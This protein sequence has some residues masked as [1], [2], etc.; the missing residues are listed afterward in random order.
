MQREN[1]PSAPNYT[2]AALAMG[3]INLLWIFILL[4]VAFGLPIVLILG[5]L[6]NKMITRL[7]NKA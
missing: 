1:I 7:G 5:F 4:W 2:N 6:I 3:L